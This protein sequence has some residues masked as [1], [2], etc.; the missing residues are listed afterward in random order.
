MSA[1]AITP[2]ELRAVAAARTW[3][4]VRA[5]CGLMLADAME[6]ADS[7]ARADIE[8]HCVRVELRGGRWYDLASA[9]K[10]AEIEPIAQA[11]RYLLA[12]G[13]IERVGDRV[14]FT[15]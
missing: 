7:C 1:T 4:P 8:C 12:R 6:I 9:N 3:L 11:A 5:S 2:D 15:S 10:T 13:L 14:R